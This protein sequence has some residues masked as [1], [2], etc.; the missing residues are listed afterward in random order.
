MNKKRADDYVEFFSKQA[1]SKLFEL[2]D[3]HQ[4]D[5]G[6]DFVV[7]LTHSFLQRY[8]YVITLNTLGA[9]PSNPSSDREVEE[10]VN[11][12]FARLK[13]GMQEAVAVGF[14]NAVSTYEGREVEY[15]C[16]LT[17]VTQPVN[18]QPC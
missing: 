9:V 8:I 15:Y 2:F 5:K 13:V 12:N 17:S 7:R 4:Q 18:K 1:A 10:F 3:Q 6:Y 16:Q 14:Q 11:K